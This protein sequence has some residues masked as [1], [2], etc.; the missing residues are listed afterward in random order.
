ML[1]NLLG[2]KKKAQ[3]PKPAKETKAK[4]VSTERFND[5][6][7]YYTAELKS[8]IAEIDDMKKQNE[9]LIKASIRSAGRAD[10][11][12]LENSKLKEELRKR[13]GSS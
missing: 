3:I 7:D 6:I 11:F 8:R 1:N 12:R 13:E 9:M 4:V 5:M 10:E 2:K